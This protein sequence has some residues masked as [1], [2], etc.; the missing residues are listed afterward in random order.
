MEVFRALPGGRS[1]RIDDIDLASPPATPG[2][3]S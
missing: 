1:E 3:G 2:S